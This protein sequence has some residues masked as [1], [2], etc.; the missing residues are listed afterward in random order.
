[1][2]SEEVFLSLG[3]NIGDSLENLLQAVAELH[4][5]SIAITDVSGIYLTE[6]VGCQ[7]QHDFL[8]MVVKGDTPFSPRKTLEI[9]QE[10][11]GKLGRVRKKRWGPRTIDIDIIFFGDY[12]VDEEGLQIPHPRFR[13]RAF[14][15]VPLKEIAPQKFNVNIF[16]PFQKVV[17]KI[18][19]ADVTMMLQVKGIKIKQANQQ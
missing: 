14:V 4:R 6:P 8:N 3:S 7:N 13:E 11:E 1:M 19:R 5:R 18:T 12:Q 16:I 2:K 10:V 15:L 9:C 17:L